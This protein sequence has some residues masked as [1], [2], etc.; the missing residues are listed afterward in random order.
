MHRVRVQNK[1]LKRRLRAI[2]SC[3]D[4]QCGSRT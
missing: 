3:V 2:V 1:Q 4:R